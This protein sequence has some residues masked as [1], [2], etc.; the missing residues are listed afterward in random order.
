MEIDLRSDERAVSISILGNQQVPKAF[1][2]IPSKRS[3]LCKSFGRWTSQGYEL[4]I[5][6]GTELLRSQVGKRSSK[7]VRRP[8]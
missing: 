4:S 8:K 3:E 6:A 2:I 7:V 1:A 5:H